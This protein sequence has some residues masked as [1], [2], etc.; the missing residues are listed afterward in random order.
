MVSVSDLLQKFN[1]DLELPEDVLKI[2]FDNDF[3]NCEFFEEKELMI[4][5]HGLRVPRKCK[6]YCFTNESEKLYV[7]PNEYE[8]CQ[9]FKQV[10][11]HRTSFYSWDSNGFLIAMGS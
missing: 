4:R 1:I 2:E 9:Y 10:T 6:C 3:N 11:E 8:V 5:V 7:I